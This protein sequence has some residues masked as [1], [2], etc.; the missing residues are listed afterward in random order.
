[1]QRKYPIAAMVAGAA[2]LIYN[3]SSD[4]SSRHQIGLA[5]IGTLLAPNVVPVTYALMCK[6]HLP[7]L[8]AVTIIED[9]RRLLHCRFGMAVDGDGRT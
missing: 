2:R 5:L 7:L 8:A 4:P 6:R 1:L 9:P 3:S